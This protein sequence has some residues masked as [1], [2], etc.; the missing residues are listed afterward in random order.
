MKKLEW[1]DRA[2]GLGMAVVSYDLKD[3][4][5]KG[6]SEGGAQPGPPGG[7][8]PAGGGQAGGQAGATGGGSGSSDLP[9]II[10]DPWRGMGPA[11]RAPKRY[12]DWGELA[13]EIRNIAEQAR[14]HQN[15]AIVQIK[16]NPAPHELHDVLAKMP[17]DS[18]VLVV[19]G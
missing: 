3:E 13:A 6:R 10:F 2:T 5:A 17:D 9:P 19:I 4:E 1:I 16:G 15:R 11:L 12:V 14:G 18:D 7:T 8:Q